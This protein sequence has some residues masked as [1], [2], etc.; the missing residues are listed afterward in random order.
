MSVLGFDYQVSSHRFLRQ[1]SGGVSSI[2][3]YR[4][5]EASNDETFEPSGEGDWS[6][7]DRDVSGDYVILI[8]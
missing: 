3:T 2:A 4:E 6:E 7:D 1:E 5:I 8:W